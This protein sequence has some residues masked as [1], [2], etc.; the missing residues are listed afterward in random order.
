[1]IIDA[2]LHLWERQQ[3]RVDGK[4]VVA[5]REGRSD[6]G[7]EI[8]QMMPPYMLEGRNTAEMLIA[9]MNYAGVSGCVVTQEYIDGNQDRYLLECKK[10]YPKRMKI[11]CLYAVS[12]THLT[13]PTIA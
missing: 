2:H 11:C 10:R 8:R 3:G 12:Y 7:G 13:L 6:F 1:M 4:P 5:L 9:N